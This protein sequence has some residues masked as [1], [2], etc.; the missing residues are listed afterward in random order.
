VVLPA[1]CFRSP[2]TTARV[3]F[4]IQPRALPVLVLGRFT[5]V[6]CI[7]DADFAIRHGNSDIGELGDAPSRTPHAHLP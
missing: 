4:E 6:F 1:V 2:S 5:P 3:V 7:V